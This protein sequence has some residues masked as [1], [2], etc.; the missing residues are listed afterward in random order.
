MGR[1]AK[2]CIACSQHR[3]HVLLSR[4]LPVAVLPCFHLFSG[5]RNALGS[6]KEK[7]LGS[8]IRNL[9]QS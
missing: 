8:D 7:L 3:K 9:K 6:V 1:G 4:K 2:Q 5:I